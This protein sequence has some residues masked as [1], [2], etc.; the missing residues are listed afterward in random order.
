ML[1]QSVEISLAS[2]YRT[3]TRHLHSITIIPQIIHNTCAATSATHISREQLSVIAI[4]DKIFCLTEIGYAK[5]EFHT[6][7]H[8]PRQRRILQTKLGIGIIGI[9]LAEHIAYETVGRRRLYPKASAVGHTTEPYYVAFQLVHSY[10]IRQN[11]R[12]KQLKMMVFD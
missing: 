7:A 5:V 4:T 12:E 10:K 2:F 9:M 8:K 3:H 6:L 1:K 11:M